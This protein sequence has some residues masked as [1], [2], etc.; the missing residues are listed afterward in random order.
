[1]FV[2]RAAAIAAAIL[3]AGCAITATE[4]HVA[5]LKR[6]RPDPRIVL[7]PLDVE[8]M[9]MDFGGVLEPKPEWSEAAR[10]YILA[11]LRSRKEKLGYGLRE[12]GADSP[13]TDEEEDLADQL[14]KLQA[15]IGRTIMR[16][17]RPMEQLQSLGEKPKW[18]LGE[19]VRVL[20]GRTGADYALFVYVR[21]S[22]ASEARKAVMVAGLALRAAIIGGV[23]SGY[24]SLVDLETGDIVWFNQLGR[25]MGDL[26]T[27]ESARE[28]VDMLLTGFPK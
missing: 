10:N 23:Q 4:S 22:Y 9:E 26:R 16:N 19:E 5:E 12:F 17:R 24:C 28:T 2:V 14:T 11:E 7:M 3:L 27:S 8:L 25:P 15:V 1:M 13:P 20:R 21:D 6:A 18:S